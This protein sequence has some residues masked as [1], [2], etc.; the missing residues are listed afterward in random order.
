MSEED[1]WL[2]LVDEPIGELVSR[3]QAE[4]SEIS[5]LVDSPRRQLAFRTFAYVRAGILLGSL[6]VDHDVTNEGS[7]TW[8]DELLADPVHRKAVEDEIRAVARDVAADPALAGEAPLGP[9]E[10]ARERF[11]AFARGLDTA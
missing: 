10:A 9:D 3:L 8:I 6:L 4:D 2:P 7:R 1:V 11:R 5:A